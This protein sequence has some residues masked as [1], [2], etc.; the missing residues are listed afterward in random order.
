M[1]DTLK[2]SRG[3][4]RKYS[5]EEALI[6]IRET[7]NRSVDKIKRKKRLNTIKKNILKFTDDEIKDICIYA[8]AQIK[9]N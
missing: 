6:R 1:S 7:N 3:R 9:R 4:P 5:D 2:K 8:L